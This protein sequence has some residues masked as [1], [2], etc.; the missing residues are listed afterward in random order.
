MLIH[1]QLHSKIHTKAHIHLYPA[2]AAAEVYAEYNDAQKWVF[3]GQAA[4]SHTT[5]GIFC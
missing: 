5:E 2:N 1:T 3:I 4:A